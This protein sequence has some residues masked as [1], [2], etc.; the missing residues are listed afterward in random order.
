MKNGETLVYERLVYEREREILLAQI[1]AQLEL[2]ESL[3]SQIT[4]YQEIVET[5]K[6]MEETLLGLVESKEQRIQNM[7]KAMA[8]G[9]LHRSLN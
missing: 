3:Q 7:T 5:N 4:A 6:K 2:I 9:R 1:K 8:N